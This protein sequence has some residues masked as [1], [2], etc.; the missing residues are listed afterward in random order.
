MADFYTTSSEDEPRASATDEVAA[1]LRHLIAE[2]QMQVGD[3]LPSEQAL[4]Q[5]FR[6]STRVVREGL[7]ALAAQGIIRTSQGRRAVVAEASPVAIEA[8]FRFVERMD[9]KSVLELYE[10][11]EVIE[12]RATAL[13]AQRATT[14]DIDRARQALEAMASAG[15]DV[16]AYVTSDIAFHAAIIDAAH[17]RFMSVV[18]TALAGALHAERELGLRNRMRAGKRSSAIREHRAVLRA[19]EARDPDRAERAIVAHM[20]SGRADTQAY[21]SDQI[22]TMESAPGR[23][24][25]P[26]RRSASS[27]S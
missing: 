17:N 19:V 14:A 23:D 11:R 4:S 22:E 2:N 10:L 9:R 24:I 5:M 12:V 26:T 21:L 25:K 1:R 3:A 15:D 20:A 27:R 8:Y 16:E 18:M 13:A 6:V 7:R